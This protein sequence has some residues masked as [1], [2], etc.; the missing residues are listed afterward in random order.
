MTYLVTGGA[1]FIGSHTVELLLSQGRQVRVLDNFS[2]GKRENLPENH[3]NLEIIEGDIRDPS[4][5]EQALHDVSHV[6]HL[7]AQVSVAVSVAKP[8]ESASHNISGFLNVA[9]AAVRHRVERL[10]FASSAAVYGTPESLPLNETAPPRPQSPYGLEKWINEQYAD[11]FHEL[12]GIS[13]LGL[14]YFNA[15]GPRQDPSSPYS[16]VISIFCDRLKKRLPLTFFGDGLQT[17]DF[18][19]VAD[20]A[21][22]NVLALESRLQGT[23]NVATGHSVTLLEMA[24]LLGQL[25]QYT[26][27]CQFASPR[28]GDIRDSAASNQKLGEALGLR[29]FTPLDAGLEKLWASLA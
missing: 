25:A 16:G 27:D 5:V 19:Y 21:C 8:T 15:Y 3:P 14:R 11:L 10:V 18:I 24:K 28:T 12:H 9:H 17:R 7:A 20:I 29:A 6:L 2:T 1:G 13:T 22:A 4:L 26:P 23:C